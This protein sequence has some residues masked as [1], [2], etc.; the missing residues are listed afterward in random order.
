MQEPSQ[1]RGSAMSVSQ[2]SINPRVRTRLG[3]ISLIAGMSCPL[4]FVFLVVIGVVFNANPALEERV[5]Y[6]GGMIMGMVSAFFMMVGP[7]VGFVCGCFA[8]STRVGKA[9]V[10]LSAL[11]L[12]AL[13]GMGLYGV[14]RGLGKEEGQPSAAQPL[15]RFSSSSTDRSSCR[16][17]FV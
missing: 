17:R 8:W 3:W 2:D 11:M 14:S 4:A 10:I 7:L 1:D 6:T 5:G 13:V 12:L 16:S 9:G 15:S